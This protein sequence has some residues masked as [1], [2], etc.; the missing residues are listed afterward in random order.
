MKALKITLFIL[1]TT[2]TCAIA[3]MGIRAGYNSAT[4]GG[5]ASGN[6][7]T[8]GFHAGLFFLNRGDKTASL[9]EIIYSSQGTEVSSGT[10]KATYKYVQL[11][12]LVN[13]YLSNEFFA[14]IGAQPGFLVGADFNGIDVSDQLNVFDFAAALGLGVDLERVLINARYNIGLTSSSKQSG[15]H[16][17]NMVLQ[18]SLGLKLGSK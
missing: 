7:S 12:I 10:I 14:Q 2:V 6:S 5:D 18:L 4:I 17:P 3:Q 16:Y 13:L 15:G 11:P 8:S 1:G 9:F